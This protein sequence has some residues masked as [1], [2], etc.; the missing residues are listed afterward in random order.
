MEE[1][2]KEKRIIYSIEYFFFEKVGEI[3]CVEKKIQNLVFLFYKIRLDE[4]GNS[5]PEI[6]NI[7]SKQ[8]L[9]MDWISC[10]VTAGKFASGEEGREK[11]PLEN[12][13]W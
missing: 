11:N 12:E 8:R 4:V 2:G 7:Q 6:A 9:M 5:V 10:S 1:E 13:N 3:A